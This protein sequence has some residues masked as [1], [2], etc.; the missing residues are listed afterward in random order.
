VWL[1]TYFFRQS[2]FLRFVVADWKPRFDLWK[3]ILAIG[4]PSG[5]EFATTTAYLLVIYSVTRP[6]GAA[7][8]AGFGIGMRVIQAGFMP[9]VALGFAVA[10]VA[11]QN[12]GARNA[13]RVKDTFKDGAIMAAVLMLVL[14]IICNI[15]PHALV[16]VFSKDPAVVAIGSDYLR[17]IS[18]TFIGSGI[19]FVASSTFQAMGNTVPS[20]ITSSVRLAVVAI[21]A[22]ILSRRPGFQLDWIW[23]MS[24]VSVVLAL[25]V[26]I[27]LLR[28]EFRRR[29]NF[30]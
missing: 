19:I 17:I 22:V 26:C 12:F 8:Q 5:F 18:W 27:L 15:A 9:V 4:L 29:L 28:R 6:F 20:F 3:R 23:Y 21:P 16:G 11:G 14:A 25:A 24:L 1:T 30:T 7:A 10:P 2:S 13:Q